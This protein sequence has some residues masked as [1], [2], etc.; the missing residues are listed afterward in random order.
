MTW[1]QICKIEPKVKDLYLKAKSYKPKSGFCANKIWYGNCGN[2]GLRDE[3][4]SLVG[5]ESKNE[6]LRTSEVYDLVYEKI[7]KALPDCDHD[8]GLC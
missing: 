5:F 3:V 1:D 8:G 7:Y 6:I 4:I 2:N